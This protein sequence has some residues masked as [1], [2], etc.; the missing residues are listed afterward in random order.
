LAGHP[1]GPGSD[2]A[3]DRVGTPIF[4]RL[5]RRL[6]ELA[7]VHAGDGV[8][9]VATG[10]GAVLFAATERVGERG[11]VIGV[12]LAVER[13]LSHRPRYRH[14]GRTRKSGWRTRSDF[15]SSWHSIRRT[16]LGAALSASGFTDV[17]VSTERALLRFNDPEEWWRWLL[18]G[19]GR[20]AVEAPD[21]KARARFQEAAF[22][23]IREIYE[24]GAPEFAEE[25]LVAVAKKPRV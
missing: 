24:G 22:K 1:G 14:A 4:G 10:R 11:R 19:G 2:A 3:Y 13:L 5:G 16:R 9:D 21:R 23:Q 7:G 17:R 15:R 25:A 6:V 20:A 18:T 8:L 12:D